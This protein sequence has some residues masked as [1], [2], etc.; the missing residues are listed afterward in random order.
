MN[1]VFYIL[2]FSLYSCL[3]TLLILLMIIDVGYSKYF[4][5]SL[6]IILTYVLFRPKY[7]LHPNNIVFA[8]S[9]FYISLPGFT[10]LC[11]KIFSLPRLIEWAYVIPIENYSLST[12]LGSVFLYLLFYFSFY[13]FIGKCEDKSQPYLLGGKKIKLLP[14]L[15]L[16]FLSICTLIIFMVKTGGISGW[17]FNYKETYLIGRSGYGLYSFLIIFLSSLTLFLLG[18]KFSSHTSGLKSVVIF[19]FALLLILLT[20][21]L[22]GFKSKI[23]IYVIIFYYPYLLNLK[24]NFNKLFAFSFIFFALLYLGTLLR[25]EGYYSGLGIFIEYFMVYFNAYQLHE[26][27]ISDFNPDLFSSFFQFI[28]KPFQMVGLVSPDVN[29]DLSVKLTKIYFPRDWYDMGATQQWPLLTELYFNFY[30]LYFGWLPVMVYVFLVSKLYKLSKLGKLPFGFIF[31]L[32]F[33]RLFSVQRGV[34]I[35]WQMPIYI[36]IYILGYII[37]KNSVVIDRS[38]SNNGRENE[39]K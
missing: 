4:G 13:L 32:E 24:V 14:I 1:K 19:F 16:Y 26:M 5:P 30:G 21:Y 6:I 12:L 29:F 23:M 33:I 35:P 31:V 38:Y 36:L 7:F 18:L 28:V 25:S 2:K 27:V 20:S 17:I 39:N 37:I 8:F 9:F 10:Q 22:T 15:I 3:V 11:Y 34:L